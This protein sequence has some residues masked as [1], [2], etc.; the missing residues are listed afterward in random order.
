RF[1]SKGYPSGCKKVLSGEYLWERCTDKPL[2]AQVLITIP[3][4]LEM[5]LM[6]GGVK[7]WTSNLKY[8]ILDEIHC[9]SEEEAGGSKWE[10]LIQMLPCPFLAMSATV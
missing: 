1:S 6:S 2:D 4:I 3:S 9:I 7:E 5:L 8:V 10:R